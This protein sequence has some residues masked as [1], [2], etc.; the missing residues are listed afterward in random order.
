MCKTKAK[1]QN[2]NN[3]FRNDALNAARRARHYKSGTHTV[4]TVYRKTSI[5]RDWKYLHHRVKITI[6][7]YMHTP[8]PCSLPYSPAYAKSP[9][10]KLRRQT[11]SLVVKTEPTSI[12]PPLAVKLN[13]GGHPPLSCRVHDRHSTRPSDG[14]TRRRRDHRHS[15]ATSKS[16]SATV[17]EIFQ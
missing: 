6:I 7:Q 8:R 15:L 16:T 14:T 12:S 13:S 1:L 11:R 2:K 10:S 17:I 5:E 9:A 3:F 4:L